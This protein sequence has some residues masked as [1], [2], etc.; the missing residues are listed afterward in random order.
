[1]FWAIF[2]RWVVGSASQIRYIILLQRSSR[3][4]ASQIRF[5][6]LLQ[7]S[8]SQSAS[9]ILYI[10]LLQNSSN[11]YLTIINCVFQILL[12]IYMWIRSLRFF[13]IQT[14]LSVFSQSC[15]FRQWSIDS[16]KNLLLYFYAH[17]G[18][19]QY[20]DAAR[21]PCPSLDLDPQLW[22]ACTWL[23]FA[24]QIQQYNLKMKTL[25]CATLPVVIC[26]PTLEQR[27]F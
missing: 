6:M 12:I 7:R 27:W 26:K 8:S 10:P 18:L 3:Q 11:Q 22:A 14:C 20:W 23:Q 4:S 13:L 5:I 19:R 17:R 21:P 16:Q 15:Q 1:M 9:Q 2:R 25:K 24:S